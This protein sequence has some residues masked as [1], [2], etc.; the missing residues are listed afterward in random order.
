MGDRHNYGL[1][2]TRFLTGHTGIP[3]LRWDYKHS[4]IESPLPYEI[5]LTGERSSERLFSRVRAQDPNHLG[6]VISRMGE[7]RIADSFVTMR[8]QSYSALLAAHYENVALP[9]IQKGE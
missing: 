7:Q 9:R 6:A 2:V 1:S 8:L 5:N 4:L 3:N